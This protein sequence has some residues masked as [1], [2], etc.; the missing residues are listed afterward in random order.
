MRCWPTPAC[1]AALRSQIDAN[2]NHFRNYTVVNNRDVVDLGYFAVD[3]HAADLEFVIAQLAPANAQ[4][5][6]ITE[7]LRS[8]VVMRFLARA[9]ERTNPAVMFINPPPSPAHYHFWAGNSSNEAAPSSPSLSFYGPALDGALQRLLALCDQDV[10]CSY[11]LGA[12]EGS[13]S[14]YLNIQRSMAEGLLPCVRE[15]NWGSSEPAADDKVK[16]SHHRNVFKNGFSNRWRS[17]NGPV[18]AETLRYMLFYA[19]HQHGMASPTE[20]SLLSLVPSMLYRLQRCNADDVKA[21][22]NLY[23]Y[24]YPFINSAGAAQSSASGCHDADVL[25]KYVWLLNDFRTNTKDANGEDVN[26]NVPMNMDKVHFGKMSDSKYRGLFEK[27]EGLSLYPPQEALATLESVAASFP[28]YTNAK[29]GNADAQRIATTKAKLLLFF[30]DLDIFFPL[31]AVTQLLAA[32]GVAGGSFQLR[33][34][35]GSGHLPLAANNIRSCIVQNLKTYKETFQFAGPEACLVSGQ[36]AITDAASTTT[37]DNA[38]CRLEADGPTAPR[39]RAAFGDESTQQHLLKFI[40]VDSAAFYGIN[41]AWQF[42]TPNPREPPEGRASTNL[43]FLAKVWRGLLALLRW[44]F[45][46]LCAVAAGYVGF[47]L[48]LRLE[49]YCR[50]GGGTDRIVNDD[51]GENWSPDVSRY[52]LEGLPPVLPPDELRG[53]GG[54]ALSGIG[55]RARALF[56]RTHRS[57]SQTGGTDTDFFTL[58][59]QQEV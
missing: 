58:V 3:Q 13:W 19:F 9:P 37:T 48:F 29:S 6:I 35:P 56:G 5:I 45:Y 47:F 40:L 11:R 43:S 24:F 4:N 14:R 27:K 17:R 51:Y 15:L 41:D 1:A 46:L 52:N 34:L 21:L 50:Q 26:V 53:G 54:G 55:E 7:G 22:R 31:P 20:T 10:S 57:F 39:A 2:T 25:H 59:R 23:A 8:A 38:R 18:A 49:D 28:T 44:F 33:A 16:A 32:Y 42:T 30:S 12:T 36:S